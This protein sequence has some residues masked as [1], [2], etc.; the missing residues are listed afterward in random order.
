MGADSSRNATALEKSSQSSSS[1]EESSRTKPSSSSSQKL[2]LRLSGESELA[3]NM[4]VILRVKGSEVH[5]RFV[6]DSADMEARLRDSLPQL[7]QA[8]ARYGLESSNLEV[9]SRAN[10]DGHNTN[11]REQHHRRR[12]QEHKSES[13]GPSFAEISRTELDRVSVRA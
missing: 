11:A 1:F 6:P 2:I 3:E 4:R 13:S 7:R 12:S 10:P 5:A 8:L 9:I